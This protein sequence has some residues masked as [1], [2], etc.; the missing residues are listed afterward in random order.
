MK[1]SFAERD[2]S[3]LMQVNTLL[4]EQV[5]ELSAS[6]SAQEKQMAGQREEAERQAELISCLTEMIEETMP[7]DTTHELITSV[8]AEVAEAERTALARMAAGFEK[9]EQQLLN[10]PTSPQQTP[11]PCAGGSTTTGRRRESPGAAAAE[12]VRPRAPWR[13]PPRCRSR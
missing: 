1:M 10:A 9:V 8:R 7:I 12:A 11:F 3:D 13:R 4:Y 2:M 5:Q 6:V